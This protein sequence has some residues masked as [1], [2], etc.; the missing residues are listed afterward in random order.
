[1]REIAALKGSFK[2]LRAAILSCIEAGVPDTH[3][4]LVLARQQQRLI[5]ERL[6]ELGAAKGIAFEREGDYHRDQLVL[7]RDFERSDEPEPE[8]QV[9]QLKTLDFMSSTG[10]VGTISPP[11]SRSV[12]LEALRLEGKVSS[13]AGKELSV[14]EG[15]FGRDYGLDRDPESGLVF[16]YPIKGNG[17]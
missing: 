2:A 14:L 11:K 8:G 17:R 15:S 9:I 13:M 16:Y 10:K 6:V 12:G 5:A 4:Q 7:A 1:M 3:P